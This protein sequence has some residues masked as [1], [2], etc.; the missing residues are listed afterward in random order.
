MYASASAAEVPLS[1]ATSPAPE[2][3]ELVSRAK[4]A[5]GPT[6]TSTQV[7]KMAYTKAGMGAVKRPCSNGR[8]ASRPYARAWG[9]TITASMR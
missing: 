1:T 4:T 6:A 8:P 5:V 9:T 3:A 2:R 7:P